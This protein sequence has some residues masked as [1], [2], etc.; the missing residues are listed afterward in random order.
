LLLEIVRKELNVHFYFKESKPE[1]D[2]Q[3][4]NQKD[5][6]ECIR[7]YSKYTA[8]M[9]K[10]LME[11]NVFEFF[12]DNYKFKSFKSEDKKKHQQT[13]RQPVEYILSVI[14]KTNNE[15]EYPILYKSGDDL[16]KDYLIFQS[17][18]LIK[19]VS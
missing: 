1:F 8:S 14:S 11:T 19:K 15:K 16:R 9:E 4:E 17:L 13:S 6:I 2:K 5:F 3:L 10:K 7:D 18:E 12:D